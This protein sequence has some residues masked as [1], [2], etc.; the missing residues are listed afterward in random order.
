MVVVSMSDEDVWDRNILVFNEFFKV[1][2]ELLVGSWVVT[3][4]YKYS[5]LTCTKDVA[6][7]TAKRRS[8]WVVAG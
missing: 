4:L 3:C 1:A 7:S 6:V 8:A 5:L 2:D